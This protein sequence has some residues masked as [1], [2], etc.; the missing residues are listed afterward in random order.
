MKN[1][2]VDQGRP[3]TFMECHTESCMPRS[4]KGQPTREECVIPFVA[5]SFSC[6]FVFVFV[7]HKCRYLVF[8]AP[9]Y[10]CPQCHSLASCSVSF[11]GDSRCSVLNHLYV[12]V[13]PHSPRAQFCT[14]PARPENVGVTSHSLK[15]VLF[16]CAFS[17]SAGT[18]SSSLSPGCR[19]HVRS[20]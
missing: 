2:R 19:T 3:A 20:S 1:L 10:F 9:V 5:W 11:P 7:F 18:L 14:V 8:V 4:P 12:C 6:F 13:R 15:H 17:L 16:S